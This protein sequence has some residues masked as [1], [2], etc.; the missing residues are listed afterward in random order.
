METRAKKGLIVDEDER[1]RGQRRATN[2]AMRGEQRR[3][4]QNGRRRRR[5]AVRGLDEAAAARRRAGERRANVESRRVDDQQHPSIASLLDGNTRIGNQPTRLRCSESDGRRTCTRILYAAPSSESASATSSDHRGLVS[6]VDAERRSMATLV[7]HWVLASTSASRDNR[8]ASCKP[9]LNRR[10]DNS[11]N[12]P[13]NGRSPSGLA[14]F[15]HHARNGG[16]DD[17]HYRHLHQPR[18]A[19]QVRE[20]S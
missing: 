17:S 9:R 15:E 18:D 11:A 16:S 19:V 3:A 1:R 7:D 2:G 14:L 6:A 4:T 20:G 5:G 13:E 10:V 12:A 8:A